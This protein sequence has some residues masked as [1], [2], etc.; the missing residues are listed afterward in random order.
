MMPRIVPP[1][2]QHITGTLFLRASEKQRGFAAI[3]SISMNCFL[4]VTSV[5]LLEQDVDVVVH[6][7]S[8]T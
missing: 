1:A 4:G 5:N 8:R 6:K 3:V 7:W 2:I